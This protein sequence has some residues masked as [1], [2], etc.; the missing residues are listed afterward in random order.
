MTQTN[1][2]KVEKKQVR[3]GCSRNSNDASSISSHPTKRTRNNRSKKNHCDG[4]CVDTHKNKLGHD[5]NSNDETIRPFENIMR[6]ENVLNVFTKANVS[7]ENKKVVS[8]KNGSTGISMRSKD[9][10]LTMNKKRNKRPLK[11]R[12]NNSSVKGATNN[13]VMVTSSFMKKECD[14]SVVL[15]ISQWTSLRDPVPLHIESSVLPVL[16]EKDHGMMRSQPQ[17]RVDK[18]KKSCLKHGISLPAALSL[19]RLHIKNRRPWCSMEKCGLGRTD[20]IN[21]CAQ[22]FEEAVESVLKL[23]NVPY[24]DES[25]QKTHHAQEFPTFPTP[26]TPD[27]IMRHTVIIDSISIKW[28]EAKM[29]YGASTLVNESLNTSAVG[30]LITK[31]EKYV[32]CYGPGAFVFAYGCGVTVTKLLKERQVIVLDPCLIP[33]DQMLDHQR[34]WCS[35]RSGEI[36][37]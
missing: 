4:Y 22:I 15:N 2:C 12:N 19:R 29:F 7:S 14:F 31:A 3:N 27:F 13:N 28:I 9:K 37:P 24:I 8:S 34:R 6:Q 32:Q 1:G 30:S 36:L 35:N 18:V 25:T 21:K 23:L 26:P 10:D 33:L 17:W 20:D 16:M 11:H 5:K